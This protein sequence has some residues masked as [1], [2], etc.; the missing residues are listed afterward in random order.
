M[1]DGI[2]K[3]MEIHKRIEGDEN[4][5][6]HW[7]FQANPVRYRIHD[8]LK[9][10]AEEWWNLHQHATEVGVGDLIAIWVAGEEAG[11]YAL[12]TVIEGPILMPDSV[13]GQGYWEDPKDGLK[14][15]PR[16]KVRYDRVLIDRP[17]L[18][19]FLEADPNLWDLRVIRAPRGT[20]FAM[21]AEEWQ[22]LQTWLDEDGFGA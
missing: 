16:V 5:V 18:K 7:L 3:P 17:L 10:E 19:I 20:N 4:D 6:G 14:A 8:S 11:I 2:A 9:R 13:R 21:R 15:K 1:I 22:A 12:G